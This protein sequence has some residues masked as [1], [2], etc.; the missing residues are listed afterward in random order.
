MLIGDR[1]LPSLD[2]G[3]S[4]AFVVPNVAKGTHY[5]RLRV[6]GIDS[7]LVLDYGASLPQFDPTQALQVP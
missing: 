4:L 7:L 1:E 2:S 3:S 5:V 6:D